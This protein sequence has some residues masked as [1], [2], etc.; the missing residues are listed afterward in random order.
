MATGYCSSVLAWFG[1]AYHIC[2]IA[3]RPWCF[4]F[5]SMWRLWGR[6]IILVHHFSPITVDST[7]AASTPALILH[8]RYLRIF[9]ARSYRSL[10]LD[11]PDFI[12]H[13]QRSGRIAALAH[14]LGERQAEVY[15]FGSNAFCTVS[16]GNVFD[17]QK[18]HLFYHRPADLHHSRAFAIL[19]PDQL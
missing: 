4:F 17:P 14:T 9:P 18:L 13:M 6:V 12:F 5:D 7:L 1:K 11:S 19:L 8:V 10:G 2:V 15:H 16:G 3:W